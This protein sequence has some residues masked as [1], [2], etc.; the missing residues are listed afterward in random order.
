MPVLKNTLLILIAF[1]VVVVL[2]SCRSNKTTTQA[3]PVQEALNSGF[4]SGKVNEI[5][6][7]KDGYTAQITTTGN[8]IYYATISR[9]NLKNAGQ[10]K[11]VA[12]GDSITVKG[13]IWQME[14]E[15][16]ITVREM[17]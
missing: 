1:F 2:T 3:K 15:N 5:K 4:I 13:D 7:G 6:P 17:K 9:V 11:T 14:K 8:L 12:V 10:Y 16:H